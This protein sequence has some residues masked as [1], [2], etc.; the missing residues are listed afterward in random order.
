MPKIVS[1]SAVSAST[2]APQTESSTAALRVY[3][4]LCGEFALVIDKDLRKLPRRQTDG[5]YIVRTE[6]SANGKGAIF[7]LN[8]TPSQPVVIERSNGYE[9]QYR[10]LCTRCTLP[11]GY[12][13]VAPPAKTDFVYLNYGGMTLQQGHVPPEAFDGEQEVQERMQAREAA[14]AASSALNP[15]ATPITSTA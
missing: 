9:R 10:H 13:L 3:Y 8:T 12:Q 2:D 14:L 5:A 4:C 11:V 1:R 7:K 15:E 6:D